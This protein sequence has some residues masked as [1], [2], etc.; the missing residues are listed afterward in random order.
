MCFLSAIHRW[1]DVTAELHYR[2]LGVIVPTIL[3]VLSYCL[4]SFMA[5]LSGAIETTKALTVGKQSRQ[6]V[7]PAALALISG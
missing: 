6:D 3:L 1:M 5:E 4:T 7:P 2:S